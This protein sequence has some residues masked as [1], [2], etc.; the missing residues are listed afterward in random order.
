VKPLPKCLTSILALTLL[1]SGGAFAL[2]PDRE[3]LR[4]E[5]EALMSPVGDGAIDSSVASPDLLAQVYEARQFAP[6]WTR[7]SQVA[8]L[9][10]L[11]TGAARSGLD[12]DDYNAESVEAG[13]RAMGG[14]APLDPAM[15]ARLDVMFTDALIRL[16]Y[17]QRFGKVNPQTLDP[18]WNFNRR[19]SE[20]DP[21]A[22]I[23]AAIDAPSLRQYLASLFPRGWVYTQLEKALGDYR[24][25]AANS[26]WPQVP[27]GPT[28]RPGDV[29]SRVVTVARRLAISGDIGGGVAASVVE[30]YTPELEQ[31]V[32]RFQARHGLEVDGII[33]G[34][35]LA[36][37]NVTAEEKVR[38]LEINLE[39]AR[40][41]F[42][43]LSDEFILVNIAGFRVY[44]V[45]DRQVVWEARAMVGKPFRKTPVF[46]DEMKYLVFNPTWTVPYSI[47]TQD[48]LPQI[49]AEPAFFEKRGFDVRDREGRVIDPS[50]VDWSQLSRSRFPYTLVQ[51]PGPNNAL[52]LVKF[53]FPNEHAVYLHDTPSKALFEK[54]DRAFSAG[55]IRVD[56]PFELA[57]VLLGRDGWT[58]QRFRE[59]LGT[60]KEQTVFL[61]KPIP[62]MLLYWTA[63]V[64]PDGTV[65]FFRDIYDRDHA[66]ADALDE[67]FRLDP[68]VP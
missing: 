49:K 44:V 4:L 55:C 39:R 30:T 21:A 10:E 50:T 24:R 1:A 46:R 23:Q 58:Q 67:P 64:S 5:L 41:V 54:A 31:A 48:L 17:H 12:P 20:R 33:G 22:T 36:A 63:Q 6:A 43:D 11:L 34:G 59:V 14:D 51:R 9:V 42:D 16:A 68:P 19:L 37:L 40:W 26:G 35:T 56:K 25:I 7:R 38:Q 45:R 47:A 29:D 18:E 3:A 66:I 52:G 27:D 32:R 53:M 61:S 65:Y 2:D 60:A 15:R 13:Y 57:E 28:L 8:E 62:V